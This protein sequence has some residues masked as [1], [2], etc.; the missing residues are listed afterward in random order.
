MKYVLEIL[1]GDRAGETFPLGERKLSIGRKADNAVVLRDEKVSGQHAEI[2][3]EDGRFVLR[4]LRSRNGTLLDGRRIQEVALNA[5]DVFQIGRTIVRFREE[6]AAPSSGDLLMHRV[7]QARL[8]QSGRRRGVLGLAALVAIL[9]AAGGAWYFL[10]GS[11]TD[12]GRASRTRRIPEVPGNK[13]A[14]AAASCEEDGA[15]EWLLRASGLGFAFG[16]PAL[17]GQAALE[18]RRE[19]GAPAEGSDHALA[20]LARPQSALAGEPLELTAWMQTAGSATGAVR[21]RFSSSTDER[22]VIRIGTAPAGHATYAQIRCEAAVPPGMDQVDVELVALLPGDDDAVVF[23][24]L[25]LARGGSGTTIDMTRDARHL[26]GAA[27]EFLIR[28]AREPVLLGLR[29]LVAGTPLEPL[30]R[31]RIVAASDAGVRAA[32]EEREDGFGVSLA[33][34]DAGVALIFPAESAAGGVLTLAESGRFVVQAGDFA[35]DNQRELVLGEGATRLTVRLPAP[36]TMRGARVADELRVEFPGATAFDLIVRHPAQAERARSALRE[37]EARIHGGQPG[38]AL[39]QLRTILE[40]VPYDSDATREAR[41]LRAELLGQLGKRLEELQGALAKAR[42]FK[43]RGSYERLRAEI[44]AVVAAWGQDNLP[45]PGAVEAM[46]SAVS[47]ELAALLAEERLAQRERLRGVIEV[48]EQSGNTELAELVR[49][50]VQRHL[51]DG[52]K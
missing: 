32:V 45:E 22:E 20:R 7:D 6:G 14:R 31:E 38:A 49:G 27:G 25:A 4:D 47:S 51:E 48:F 18:A 46:R 26:I 36:G 34:G 42:F 37:A 10:Q 9:A 35:L 50:Y 52:G 44:D 1:E 8:A 28:S 11:G 39:T 16:G 2:V 13:L 33:G 19:A 30:A 17:T 40:E 21:L 5:F 24:D 15:A 23:D 3:F 43:I 41:R 12:G 29:P